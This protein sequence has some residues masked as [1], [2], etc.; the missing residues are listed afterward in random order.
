MAF[1]NIKALLTTAP[2]LA[3]LNFSKPFILDPDECDHSVGAVLSQYDKQGIEHLLTYFSCTLLLREEK[4]HM[5][6]KECLAM[7]KEMKHFRSYL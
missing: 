1:D 2:V 7:V 6:Q 5:T 4:Y 3:Y